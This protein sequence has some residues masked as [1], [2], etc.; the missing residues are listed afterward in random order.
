M[1]RFYLPLMRLQA[2]CIFFLALC[3]SACD[4]KVEYTR[5]Y[6]VYEPQYLSPAE[7]RSSFQVGTAAVLQEPG[8]I[9]MY[10][11]YLFINEPGKGIHV[12][13]NANK[14]QPQ[15]INFINLPGN[16]DFAAKDGK[17]NADSIWTW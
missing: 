2:F 12:I 13:N 14:Q 5:T 8:K 10:G 4:D 9:Y 7:I 3:I 15:P 6:T 1:T 17:L 16:Y 11:D